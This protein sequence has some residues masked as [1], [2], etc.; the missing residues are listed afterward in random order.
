MMLRKVLVGVWTLFGL[1]LIALGLLN[2]ADLLIEPKRFNPGYLLF[3]VIGAIALWFS[4]MS[5]AII[6]QDDRLIR[7]YGMDGF[8][9]IIKDSPIHH[10]ELLSKRRKREERTE[11][12]GHNQKPT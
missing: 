6:R 1:G 11:N 10:P 3:F 4:W 8:K 9:R 2:V 5:I 7:K 12:G